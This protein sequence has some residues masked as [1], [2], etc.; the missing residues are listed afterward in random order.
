MTYHFT[1]VQELAKALGAPVLV[2][3]LE[4]T[5]F[6]GRANFGITEVYGFLVRTDSDTL[7]EAGASFGAL[8]DPERA[9]SPEVVALTGITQQMVRGQETW[10]KRYAGLFKRMAAGECWV[11][12]FNNSTFDNYAVRDMNERYGEPFEKFEKTFDIRSLHN[13]LLNKKANSKGT[14]LDVAALY[15][16]VPRGALHRAQADVILT[17]ET[18]N[19]IIETHGLPSVLALI[20]DKPASAPDKLTAKAISKYVR[21]K[22]QVSI[23]LLAATFKKDAV[24][25]SIEVGKAID[26]RLVD[27]AVFAAPAVQDWL[28]E[29][30]PSVSLETLEGGKLR[31]VMDSLKLFPDAPPELDYIQLRVALLQSGI[32]WGSLKPPTA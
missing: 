26:E 2:Y 10:G 16:V 21:G 11:A 29:A 9:I 3:D 25:A 23:E 5:T 12:G 15:N 24:A 4:A 14:L 18:L 22:R 31:P 20:Q 19:A 13:T 8:I 28:S 6:R 27:P 17:L 7:A 30:L 32:S 1:A